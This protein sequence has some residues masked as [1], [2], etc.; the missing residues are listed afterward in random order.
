MESRNRRQE[1]NRNRRQKRAPIV[2][3]ALGAGGSG[4]SDGW[5]YREYTD[6]E[7]VFETSNAIA[8]V[9][10]GPFKFSVFTFGK[11]VHIVYDLGLEYTDPAATG[12]FTVGLPAELEPDHNVSAVHATC[13]MTV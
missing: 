10:W 2:A 12:F 4:G 1:S 9:T 13:V 3:G 6:A 8:C 11:L 7:I 5:A